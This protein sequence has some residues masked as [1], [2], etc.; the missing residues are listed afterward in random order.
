MVVQVTKLTLSDKG[1]NLCDAPLY[2]FQVEKFKC[3]FQMNQSEQDF[4]VALS[5][6]SC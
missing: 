2:Q 6:R 4:L 5:G 3:A 1:S